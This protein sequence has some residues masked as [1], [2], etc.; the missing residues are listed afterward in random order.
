[1]ERPVLYDVG[2]CLSRHQ[3]TVLSIAHN[4]GEVIGPGAWVVLPV[5]QKLSE[6][7]KKKN[8]KRSPRHPTE[9]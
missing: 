1:M 9:N 8:E 6:R 5:E 7:E 4:C 2:E 3:L